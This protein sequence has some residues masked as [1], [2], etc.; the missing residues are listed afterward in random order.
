MSRYP[1]LKNFSATGHLEPKTVMFNVSSWRP[2][3]N[4]RWWL[5]HWSDL[6]DPTVFELSMS[7]CLCMQNSTLSARCEHL[8][9]FLLHICP[10]TPIWEK[11]I[12][13]GSEIVSLDRALEVHMAPHFSL[14]RTVLP[15]IQYMHYRRLTVTIV[16]PNGGNVKCPWVADFRHWIQIQIQ[17]RLPAPYIDRR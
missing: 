16:R 2:Y 9:Q 3:W 14:R 13:I 1:C 8:D 12:R 10:T 6:L 15:Q 7:K 5:I 4:S 17:Y 11:G